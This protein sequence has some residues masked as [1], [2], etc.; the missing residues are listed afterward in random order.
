MNPTNK[1]YIDHALAKRP[2]KLIFW[3]SLE[4]YKDFLFI[5]CIACNEL[6]LEIKSYDLTSLKELDKLWDV[7]NRDMKSRIL[8]DQVDVTYG[9][10]GGMFF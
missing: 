9:K 4:K 5:P 10:R 3:S 2:F 1:T 8:L 7:T 6:G